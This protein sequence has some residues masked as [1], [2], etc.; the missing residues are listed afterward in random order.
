VTK[1]LAIYTGM[2]RDTHKKFWLKVVDDEGVSEEK[3]ISPTLSS[4]LPFA[5]RSTYPEISPPIVQ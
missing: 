1:L 2:R 4:L 5:Q 3:D